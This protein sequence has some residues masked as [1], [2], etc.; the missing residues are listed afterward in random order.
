M[1][2]PLSTVLAPKTAASSQVQKTAVAPDELA[3]YRRFAARLAEA[4][5]TA[6]GARGRSE[7]IMPWDGQVLGSVP[8]CTPQ[9]VEFALK[10]AREAQQ[11]WAGVSFARRKA[12][13]LRFHDLVLSHQADLLDILQ[14][15]SGKARK[16]AAEEALDVVITSRH[17]AYHAAGYL[18]P[19]RRKGALPLITETR[20][21]RHPLGVAGVIAPWNYPLTLAISD[22][23]P[24]LMAGNAVLLKPA[25]ETPFT[26]LYSLQL[27]QE[28]GL[29]KALF[30]I[31][32]GRGRELGPALITGADFLMF[33]GSTAT[34]RR[35]AE[36]AA[37]RLIPFSMELGGKNPALVLADADLDQAA[38]GLARGAFSNT[39]QLCISIERIYVDRAV[40]QPFLE[41][42]VHHT[43]SLGIGSGLN[44]GYHIG[45]LISREQLIK[46][47]EHV[48]DAIDQGAQL[49]TGGKAREDLGPLYYEPTILT[50][51]KPG[52]KVF[53]EET[54]GP[55]VCVYP[56]DT[57]EEAVRLA[58]DSR[59]GLNSSIWTRR[60]G[61]ALRVAR[62]IQT[63]TVNINEPYGATFASI[64]APMGGMKMSGVGRRHGSEGILKFTEAQTVSIQ[65]LIP[66][67]PFGPLDMRR[68]TRAMTLLL[69]LIRRIPG[70]R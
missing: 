42:L 60:P 33:T 54:F 69:R 48:A 29:P 45:S 6:G 8:V 21:Y 50:G 1:E 7:V 17:Y 12:I 16:D 61:K 57:P 47:Q 55:L 25:E 23:I 66:L 53:A 41:R 39:G 19:R 2:K 35:L 24:A 58:N 49:V 28:A 43:R 46:V 9:D 14:L 26:A 38:G 3:S 11:T 68:F 63:G 44:F 27:M 20:E 62:Q 36:Q 52:M 15:E 65:R 67:A 70:L 30:Q 31:L 10:T 59:Y 37:G 13:L 4:V 40:Y 5:T 56:F 22:A 51:V 34:G 64:D 18:K 32:T